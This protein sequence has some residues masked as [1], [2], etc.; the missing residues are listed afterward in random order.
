MIFSTLAQDIEKIA[1]LI[2]QGG[3]GVF[4][5]DTV[6]ALGGSALDESALRRIYDLR[7]R[8]LHKP[9]QIHIGALADLTFWV[10]V[11]PVARRIIERYW[12]GPLT[13]IF[14]VIPDRL[15]D[16]I[17]AGTGTVAVR[18]PN[19][20]VEVALIN[21]SGVPLVAPSANPSGHP[22]ALT[23]ADSIRYFEDRI[24]FYL[25]HGTSKTDQV[26]TLIDLTGETPRVVREGVIPFSAG[27]FVIE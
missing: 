17:T 25:D 2:K 19:C 1:R 12:P 26:S 4:P 14:K 10:E 24:D 9:L 16:W 21:A 27:E 3:V 6:Y 15:S 18:F 7:N 8:P 22:P 5:T 23:I 11:S 20:P 13:I